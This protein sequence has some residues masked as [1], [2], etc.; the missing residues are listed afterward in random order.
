MI[1]LPPKSGR[2]AFGQT[3]EA[4]GKQGALEAGIGRAVVEAATQDFGDEGNGL[5]FAYSG[6]AQCVFPYKRLADGATW[7]I[8]AEHTEPGRPPVGD[9]CSSEFLGVP[10]GNHARSILSSANRG[11]SDGQAR[12]LIGRIASKMARRDRRLGRQDD[13]TVGPGSGRARQPLQTDIPH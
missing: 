2:G 7:G 11:P 12:G 6:W 8:A 9:E 13:G 4:S 5:R 3:L 1:E 10:F